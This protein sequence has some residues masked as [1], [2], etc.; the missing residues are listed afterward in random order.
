MGR[1]ARGTVKSGHGFSIVSVHICIYQLQL[2]S[3]ES[4]ASVGD[5]PQ[6]AFSQLLDVTSHD[7]LNTQNGLKLRLNT[8]PLAPLSQTRGTRSCSLQNTSNRLNT[9][10][11]FLRTVRKNTLHAGPQNGEDAHDIKRFSGHRPHSLPS[12]SNTITLLY[13]T[14]D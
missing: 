13:R 12:I 6:L 2:T 5:V 10:V 8:I 1:V 4:V 7:I 3:L 11:P 14:T 9:K